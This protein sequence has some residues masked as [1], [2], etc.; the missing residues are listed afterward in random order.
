MGRLVVFVP[1][2]LAGFGVPLAPAI[3]VGAGLLGIV[4]YVSYGQGKKSK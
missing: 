4:A 2:G 3:A 1:F